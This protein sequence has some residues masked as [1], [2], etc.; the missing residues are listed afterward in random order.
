MGHRDGPPGWARDTV[1]QTGP[2][3]RLTQISSSKLA[4][5]KWEKNADQGL[6]IF[7]CFSKEDKETKGGIT[8]PAEELG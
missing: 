1:W 4:R 5:F 3:E 8:H 7:Q 6:Q 2:L